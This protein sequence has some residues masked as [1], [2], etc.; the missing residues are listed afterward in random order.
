MSV[1]I[2][3]VFAIFTAF[4]SGV[5]MD[6]RECPENEYWLACEGT[7]PC[8]PSCATNGEYPRNCA[9]PCSCRCFYGYVR[10][11]DGGRCIPKE[12]CP[13]DFPPLQRIATIPSP[14][15]TVVFTTNQPL[16]D[17]AKAK[18]LEDFLTTKSEKVSSDPVK[19]DE[20]V[21]VSARSSDASVIGTEI[22]VESLKSDELVKS[23]ETKESDTSDSQEVKIKDDDVQVRHGIPGGTFEFLNRIKT[24]QEEAESVIARLKADEIEANAVLNR[25]KYDEMRLSGNKADDFDYYDA[26]NSKEKLDD[27][28]LH[29]TNAVKVR[30]DDVNVRLNDRLPRIKVIRNGNTVRVIM[31]PQIADA[32]Y[33]SPVT[34]HPYTISYDE[35]QR[36]LRRDQVFNRAP[37][38]YS[39]GGKSVRGP[40]SST[41]YQNPSRIPNPPQYPSVFKQ[42]TPYSN[43]FESSLFPFES[44]SVYQIPSDYPPPSDMF[45]YPPTRGMLP[46]SN[47]Y[48]VQSSSNYPPPYITPQNFP[49]QSPNYPNFPTSNDVCLSE[50]G[51]EQ[52]LR[53][54]PP[55]SKGINPPDNGFFPQSRNYMASMGRPSMDYGMPLPPNGFLED[56]VPLEIFDPP[57]HRQPFMVP[58]SR[59]EGIL[60]KRLLRL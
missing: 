17:D 29:D 16:D 37:A 19:E 60:I 26:L 36:M 25:L 6:T 8:E 23:D 55:P 48:L 49:S 35:P 1:K 34:L 59:N 15:P 28:D 50:F 32:D 43:S 39:S 10:E 20:V 33:A 12:S 57:L 21:E 7:M 45:D 51:Q 54:F 2:H 52:L 46:S 38:R 30:V 58:P 13:V 5:S 3:V 18:I 53:G 56:D 41:M 14:E 44:S 9:V 47:P 4:I 31:S 27:V 24:D 42:P 11:A 22:P 40:T